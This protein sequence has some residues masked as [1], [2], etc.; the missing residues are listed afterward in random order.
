[1]RL[2]RA[3]LVIAACGVALVAT[4]ASCLDPTQ[5]TVD[6]STDMQCAD[7]KG[8]SIVGGAPGTVELATPTTTTRDCDNG[9][10]GT[11]VSTP[12]GSK[13]VDAAFVVVMG[14]DVP[15]SQCTAAN[16]FKGC[17]V[18]RRLIHY[19]PHTPLNLPITMWLV[20]KDVECGPDTTCARNGKC[21]SARIA[22]PAACAAS[23]CFIE[24][25]GPFVPGSDGGPADDA[26][27]D[28]TTTD[29]PSADGPT[30]DGPP[31]GDAPNDAPIVVPPPPVGG[32]YCPHKIES[33]GQTTCGAAPCCFSRSGALGHCVPPACNPNA[34]I[35]MA[36]TRKS[37]CALLEFCAGEVTGALE[38][39]IARSGGSNLVNCVASTRTLVDTHC[40]MTKPVGGTWICKT[41]ADCP[42]PSTCSAGSDLF[43]P[44]NA[45][46]ECMP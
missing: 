35:P 21:T 15:V 31:I 32:F 40:A 10:I 14:V 13:D 7:T 19:I 28:G 37:D 18:E 24:G 46:G 27:A 2:P 8:T 12:A 22:D 26:I 17:I 16:H 44:T 6:I 45:F 23:P 39:A 9:R 43:C 20:C 36:C 34:E 4:S 42:A 5:I 29:G 41:N 3:A 30:S 11:L 25:D 1:M 38:P 33:G